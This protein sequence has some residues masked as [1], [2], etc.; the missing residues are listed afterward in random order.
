MKFFETPRGNLCL[1]SEPEDADMLNELFA[2]C[3]HNETEFL[4]ELL[5]ETGWSANGHLHMVNP[6]DV[7]ALTDS[8]LMTN[9][10]TIDDDGT[11]SFVDKVW[12]YPNYMVAN[13]AEKLLKH[14]SVTLMLAPA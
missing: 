4:S 7:G 2:R 9:D 8:P 6:E 5:A 14:G 1:Q 11:L 10:R 13:P 3:G 12:W